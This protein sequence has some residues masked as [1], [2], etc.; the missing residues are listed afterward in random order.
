MEIPELNDAEGLEAVA[1]EESIVS[2]EH[3][4]VPQT[5]TT[6][7]LRQT[8]KTWGRGWLHVKLLHPVVK[9]AVSQHHSPQTM[10]P[11][12]PLEIYLDTC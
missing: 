9:F 1:Q 11:R 2:T 3:T 5:Y 7:S 10:P 4:T 12:H 6:E 8:I